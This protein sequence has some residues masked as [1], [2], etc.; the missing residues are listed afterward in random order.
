MIV[1]IIQTLASE[2]SEV[3]TIVNTVY[4]MYEDN[5]REDV[6]TKN[7]I[8]GMIINKPEWTKS[9]I[10]RHILYSGM[11]PELHDDMVDKIFHGIIDMHNQHLIDADKK[12]LIEDERKAF[13]DTIKH[14]GA[15]SRIRRTG[16]GAGK[17]TR[18]KK[19]TSI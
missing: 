14:Y 17:S 13:M 7:P 4:S 6:V 15:W 5:V 2:G 10:E 9:S 16:V 1:H 3:A 18:V 12:R 11:C 8:S 19:N